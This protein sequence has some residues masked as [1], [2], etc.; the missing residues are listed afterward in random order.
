[1]NYTYNCPSAKTHV[2]R[3]EKLLHGLNFLICVIFLGQEAQTCDSSGDN[4]S[5]IHKNGQSTAAAGMY[6]PA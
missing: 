3:S 2:S 6:V 5:H 1:M 4:P